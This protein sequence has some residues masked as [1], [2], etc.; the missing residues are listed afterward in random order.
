MTQEELKQHIHYDPITGA[1]TRLSR[2]NSGGS[3]DAYGYLILKIKGQQY[4]SHRL[5]WLYAYGEMPNGNI[6][7]INGDRADNRLANLRVVDQA[8]NCRNATVPINPASGYPGISVDTTTKG[9]KKRYTFKFQGRTYRFYCPHE[10][11]RIRVHLLKENNY[12]DRH[13][14]EHCG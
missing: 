12:G 10:A 14:Q 8:T 1:I 6:D 11:N 13:Y 5:A 3:T 7:H 9:L 4:K 2:R